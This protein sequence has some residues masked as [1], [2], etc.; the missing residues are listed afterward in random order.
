MCVVVAG[1]LQ[2]RMVNARVITTL[3]LTARIIIFFSPQMYA[4]VMPFLMLDI[5]C[6]CCEYFH[7]NIYVYIYLAATRMAEER[8]ACDNSEKLAA[9]AWRHSVCYS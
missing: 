1:I 7:I 3:F 2:L 6:W 4:T 9:S 5:Y 8:V